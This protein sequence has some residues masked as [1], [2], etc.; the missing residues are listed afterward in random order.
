M[1]E[2]PG[3][4]APGVA[5]ASGVV[6][7]FAPLLVR[8]AAA[9]SA[10]TPLAETATVL[11]TGPPPVDVD[12]Y[13]RV[14]PGLFVYRQRARTGDHVG[15][16]CDIRADAFVDGI[17]LGHE[18]VRPDRVEGLA[19]HLVSGARR[20]DLVSTLHRSG[21]LLRQ[22]LVDVPHTPPVLEFIGADGL[23]QALWHLP[24]GPDTARL[25]EE[26]GAATH[27]IADG[28]HRVA[29]NLEVWRRD[30]QPAEAG[31][32]CV[33]YPVNG[34]TLSAFDR[35]VAGPVDPER[36]R[37]LL[38]EDFDLRE[39]RDAAEASAAGVGV[40]LGRTWYAVSFTGRRPPGAAGLDVS[41]LHER[42]LAPLTEGSDG[43]ALEI[44][45][46]RTSLEPLIDACHHDGGVLF[47]L[48]APRVDA[49][50]ELADAGEVVPAK[51]TYF[52]PKPASGLFLRG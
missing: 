2:T 15:V 18:S 6:R 14:G 31:V 49:L 35:R 17:V 19:Q 46:A 5:A 42:V 48:T 36:V 51:T 39:V 50:I 12:A 37:D 7:P 47:A 30:G 8:P 10:V 9:P 52:E 23:E 32:L 44:A 21:P 29:A 38:A 1:T 3:A 16:V 4:A 22:A 13:E 27:Y 33:A 11:A 24:A 26:L 28:H 45:P 43:R 20:V 41:L 40:Y 34:L 25:C